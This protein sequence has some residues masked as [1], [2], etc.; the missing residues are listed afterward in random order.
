VRPTPSATA[1]SSDS[2]GS[3]RSAS[4]TSK[5]KRTSTIVVRK[6]SRLNLRNPCSNSDAGAR[7]PRRFAMSPN[8]VRG[9][10]ASATA[11]AVPL[12][13]EVPRKTNAGSS[14]PI[15][16]ASGAPACLSTGSDSPVS[17]A[18]WTERSRAS[19]RRASAG[20]RSPADRRIKSPG[21]TARREISR[22]WPSRSTV[23]VGA[24]DARR[25]SAASWDRYV[26]QK[27][28]AIPSRTIV[29]MIS[30]SVR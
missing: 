30:A 2:I 28:I 15:A 26:C 10:V 4:A 13:T 29:M 3:R 18:C 21:T 11:M 17:I 7:V 9:P 20:T 8:T 24:T 6:I 5:M 25:R 1:N 16:T 12:T 22:H 14:G 23:A 19:S 27:L